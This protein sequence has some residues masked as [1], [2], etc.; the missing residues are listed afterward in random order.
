MGMGK[1][2]EI[3]ALILG[4]ICSEQNP[5]IPWDPERKDDE[6]N[7]QIFAP[8]KTTL[9]VCPLSVLAQECE[10]LKVILIV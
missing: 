7:Q 3:L 8:V 9:I 2:I 5:S 4:N 10:N 1:T 6:G